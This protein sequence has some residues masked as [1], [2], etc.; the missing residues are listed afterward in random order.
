MV[1]IRYSEL[2]SGLHVRAA[3]EG[4]RTIIY[5]QPGLTPAERRAA[6]LRVRSSSRMGHG[7]AVPPLAMML[8]IGADQIRTTVQNGLA[9]MR[10]HPVLL[11]PPLVLLVS[12]GIVFVL[13]SF[14]TFT[15]HAHEQPQ[16]APT[17][18][19]RSGPGRPGGQGG[20]DP[21]SAV[22]GQ[23]SAPG[24]QG[25]GHAR[26][27][28]PS[29]RTRPAP[30]P[31]P[32]SIRSPVPGP[33]GRSGSS[34]TPSPTATQSPTPGVSPTPSP[35]PSPSASSSGTC[36]QLGPLGLCVTV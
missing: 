9:A 16:A 32:S 8:A 2:P 12:T 7:P 36:L 10:R 5:L 21:G 4:W 31:A 24:S 33:T 15:V 14:V 25:G 22:P 17:S 23:A 18:G 28:G 27:G 1:K 13:M 34:P 29:P 3:G 19:L 26:H 30:S 35:T 6:L 20:S 11:L